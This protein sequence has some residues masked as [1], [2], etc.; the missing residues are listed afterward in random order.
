VGIRRERRLA[1]GAEPIRAELSAALAPVR[2][3]RTALGRRVRAQADA[4][5]AE[6]YDATSAG[7][8]EQM[9][10]APRGSS[11]ARAR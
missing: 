11:R 1:L 8:G 10:K 2:A 4:F 9:A 7:V 6:Q 5:V 3:A